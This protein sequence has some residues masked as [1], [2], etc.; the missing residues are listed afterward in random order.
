MWT[1]LAIL[2]SVVLFFGV[3]FRRLFLHFFP[4]KKPAQ[5]LLI[6]E[7]E[8]EEKNAR[9]K[10][11]ERAKILMLCGEA[12][13]KAQRG[14]IQ[15]AIKLYIQALAI[16]DHNPEAQEKL[17]MLYLQEQLFSPAAALFES[18]AKTT[19]NPIHFSNLGISLFQQGDY[20]SAKKAYIESLKIDGTRPQRYVSLSHVYRSLGLLY[21]ALIA[22]NKAIEV[23]QGAGENVNTDFWFLVADLQRE[24]GLI[25]A[26]K[27]TLEGVLILDENNETARTMLQELNSQNN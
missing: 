12:D 26:A 11:G 13:K 5:D 2:T 22:M 24:A 23:Q 3:F 6:E 20:D 18:L 10:K 8:I 1:F 17:A 16:E 27:A 7:D 9:L 4:N 21:N 14:E 25:D 15:E 19:S